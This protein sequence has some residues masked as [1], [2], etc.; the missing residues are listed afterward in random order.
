MTKLENYPGMAEGETAY[1]LP[2]GA[3]VAV[4]VW[5]RMD[6]PEGFAAVGMQARQ[7]D[8][9][10]ATVDI[11]PGVPAIT[12]E[13]TATVSLDAFASGQWTVASYLDDARPRMVEYAKRYRSEILALLE[14][15]QAP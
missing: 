5:R 12:P 11:A 3:V 2:G 4:R 15:P 13:K 14:L 8:A 1:Q 6:A 9:A 10:G 7:V